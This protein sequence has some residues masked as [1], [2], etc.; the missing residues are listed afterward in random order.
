MVISTFETL[1]KWASRHSLPLLITGGKQRRGRGT[2]RHICHIRRV[3]PETFS[4]GLFRPGF[5]KTP[6]LFGG[7]DV[8]TSIGLL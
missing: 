6:N 8:P 7:F 4:G 5:P 2:L 1:P 3:F